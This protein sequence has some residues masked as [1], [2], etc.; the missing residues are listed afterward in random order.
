MAVTTFFLV[1]HAERDTGPD[2]LPGRSPGIRLTGRGRA[3]A[4]RIATALAARGVDR[5]VSS[6]LERAMETAAPLAELTGLRVGTAAGFNEFD[7]GAWTGRRVAELEADSLWQQ[8]N[9]LRSITRTPGG[10]VAG[11][12]Q[13]RFVTELLRL[14]EAAPDG[15]IACFSHADPI[16]FALVHFFGAPIDFFDRI[17]IDLG[18]I[19]SLTLAEWG[20]RVV[21]VN[22][23]P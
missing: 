1:R 12:V 4:G 19:T 16:R 14:R 9:R 7:F 11:E 20:A 8:F 5:I 3:Q 6:P 22:E 17:E 2:L 15:R 23:V 21:R 10:E 18:S 13:T